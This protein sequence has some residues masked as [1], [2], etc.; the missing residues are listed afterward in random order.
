MVCPESNGTIYIYEG[1]HAYFFLNE[2][3]STLAI[4]FTL[5]VSRPIRDF[6]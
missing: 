5:D 2:V 4:E 1:Y 6:A 3:E